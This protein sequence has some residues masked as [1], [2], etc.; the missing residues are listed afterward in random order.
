MRHNANITKKCSK[1]RCGITPT[2]HGDSICKRRNEEE[3]LNLGQVKCS[4]IYL[5]LVCESGIEF[6]DLQAHL[7]QHS[8]RVTHIILGGIKHQ[9]FETLIYGSL[10]PHC[11]F[12]AATTPTPTLSR[13][14]SD[15][16]L[17]SC[18]CEVRILSRLWSIWIGLNSS[19]PPELATPIE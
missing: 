18:W 3:C 7:L 19:Q 1:V 16:K 5:S 6:L 9:L 8:R 14:S 12:I 10:H 11:L 4:N 17:A 2:S 13:S 15:N